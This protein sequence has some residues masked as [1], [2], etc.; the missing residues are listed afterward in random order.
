M[1]RKLYQKLFFRKS[2]WQIG[3]SSLDFNRFPDITVPSCAILSKSDISDR[4]AAF[5]AD[6]F[7]IRFG[8][9]WYLFFEIKDKK[10]EKGVIGMASS[11]DFVKWRYE[12]VVLQEAW[13][14]SY[15]FVFVYENTLYM[16]PESGENR[17]V[18]LYKADRSLLHWQEVRTLLE[19][20]DFRDTTLWRKE[21]VWYFFTSQN[22]DDNLYLYTSDDLFGTLKPH[23]QNPLLTDEPRFSRSGG[24]IFSLDDK[25]YRLSQD[26]SRRYGEAL[27]L[28]EI[29]ALGKEA[30]AQKPLQKLLDPPKDKEQWN[31]RKMHHF[32]VVTEGGKLFF[33]VDGEGWQK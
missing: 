17:S 4:D 28:L 6:P 7:L 24:N 29:T 25:L 23:P 33:A 11:E 30:F 31:S 20:E 10:A 9:K 18:K 14:L 12:G 26:C 15:P 32:S 13:H 16:I 27:Y 5:V 2:A 3:V 1:F 19:G 22:S 21:G 8:E